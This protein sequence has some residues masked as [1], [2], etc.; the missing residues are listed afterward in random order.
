M[1]FSCTKNIFE[2]LQEK[3]YYIFL[4]TTHVGGLGVNLTGANR[5]VIY[6]PDWNPATDMQARE[7]AWR[8]G[9][10]NQVTIYRLVTSGTIE[11]KIY[12]RQIFK[13]F[14]TNKVLKDPSQRRFF[15]SND[16]YELFTYKDDEHS[17]ETSAIFAGT[18]F[19]LN[20]KKIQSRK[21]KEK[22]KKNLSS[23]KPE[24][25]QNAVEAQK[26]LTKEK[27]EKMKQM[28]QILSRRIAL[29]SSS[30]DK[31]PENPGDLTHRTN[32][33]SITDVENL[34]LVNNREKK[35]DKKKNTKR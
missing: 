25:V 3:K 30:K 24:S 1:P 10:E 7:R 26:L 23:I 8:I 34:K 33:D 14:L 18:N 17:N 27:I 12:H 21:K 4:S 9:Q 6:D 13:Q 28:A 29:N 32:Q 19:E 2:L 5:V 20:L 16:L 22:S 11:E 15:K 35:R 31:N